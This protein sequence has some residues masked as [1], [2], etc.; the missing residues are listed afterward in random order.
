MINLNR[1]INN[2]GGKLG[3]VPEGRYTVLVE[4]AKLG[5]STKGNEKNFF[6]SVYI[7]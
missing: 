6:N 1:Y 2:S 7:R 4:E 5:L 3:P